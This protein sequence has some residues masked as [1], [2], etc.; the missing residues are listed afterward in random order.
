MGWE[1]FFDPFIVY[2]DL[3]RTGAGEVKV[4]INVKF[5]MVNGYNVLKLGENFLW[6]NFFVWGWMLLSCV[7]KR[8][9]M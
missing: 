9:L 8:V 3:Y 6:V 4:K 5:K 1:E 2:G 7:I